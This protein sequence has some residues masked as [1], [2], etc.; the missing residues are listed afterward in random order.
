MKTI[1]ITGGSGNLGKAVV[2]RFLKDGHQV[3]ATVSPGKGLGYPTE[4]NIQ[5]V[6]ADLTDEK[7]VETIVADLIATH[8]QID[9]ALLLVGGYEGGSIKATNGTLVKKM[10]ALNFETAYFV[11]RPVF[12]QM[13]QQGPGGRIMLVGSRPALH[14]N[15]GK[16]S[17]A[18]GLSK[19]LIFKLADYLNAESASQHVITSVVV[20]GTIDTPTNRQSMP[21]ADFTKWNKPADIANA[22]ASLVESEKT[23]LE[24]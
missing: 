14:P 24:L 1:L 21:T 9:V 23:I 2:E 17:L 11:A 10:M 20:P 15:E 12:L 4:G 3:V 13:Q 16:K 5:T 18:Y 22:I 6:E 7:K 8:G 19:S